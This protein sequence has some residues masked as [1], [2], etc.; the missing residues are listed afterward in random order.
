MASQVAAHSSSEVLPVGVSRVFSV[1]QPNQFALRLLQIGRLDGASTEATT[2]IMLGVLLDFADV[3]A[4]SVCGN[5]KQ[6][7]CS[8]Q[9]LF[10]V[11]PVESLNIHCSVVAHE[12][13]GFQHCLDGLGSLEVPQ[14]VNEHS[15][16]ID[17]GHCL[18]DALHVLFAEP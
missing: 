5:V 8:L 9:S 4:D 16:W 12:G 2:F 7:A 1:E 6:E 18:N 14:M 13:V 11:P 3:V 10:G 17:I 15:A